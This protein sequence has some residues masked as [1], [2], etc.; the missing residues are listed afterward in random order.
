[1]GLIRRLFEITGDNTALRLVERVRGTAKRVGK[2][3]NSIGDLLLLF[4]EQRFG[5]RSS[6]VHEFRHYTTATCFTCGGGLSP[7]RPTA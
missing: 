2:A 5:S 6:G 7:L 1:M 3:S 4:L